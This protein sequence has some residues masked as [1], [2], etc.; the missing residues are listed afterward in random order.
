MNFDRETYKITGDGWPR[1]PLIIAIV[2]I[3]GSVIAAF[4]D[5][6]RFYHSFL[7]AWSFWFTIAAGGL[8]FTMMHHLVGA[9]WSVVL[10]RFS[11]SAMLVVP[12][13]I[14]GFIVIVLGR[15]DL[16]HWTH[17]DAMARDELLKWKEPYLNTGFFII[18]GLVFFAVWTF[19][20][21][22]LR[23][24]SLVQDKGPNDKLQKRFVKISAPGMILFAFTFTFASIDW[25]MSLEPHWFSTIYG[26]YIFSG[27]VVGQ[28]CF[29]ILT[30]LFL[31]RRQILKETIGV[32]HF[33]DL[34]RLL[35]AFMVF[36]GYM[37]FS[38]YFL[39]WYGNIPEET[40]WFLHRWQG[41][42][43]TVSLLLV[44]GN[45]VIPFFIMITW[46]AKR[47]PALLGML[48]AWLLLMH[49]VDL[50]W[51]VMPNLDQHGL[52]LTWI[53]L[54]CLLAVGGVFLIVFWRNFTTAPI[55]PV[56]DERLANSININKHS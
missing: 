52:H 48:A 26:V 56:G 21:F 45:F 49:Y 1:I 23:K 10:R 42:W 7:V 22:L 27:A 11:E 12:W 8:F 53:D 31:H 43:K 6:Q 33:H 24:T 32:E 20:A 38:Q 2:G 13:M 18:R 4:T 40:F 30:V 25:L 3:A 9:T 14:L 5:G 46:G 16:F 47:R 51:L 41:S 54:S 50:Y 36:W 55:V 34:G 19:L 35:F 29:V 15:H 44:M 28:L 37:A 17:A 39:I